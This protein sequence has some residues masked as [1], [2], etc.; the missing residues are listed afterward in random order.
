MSQARATIFSPELALLRSTDRKSATRG[1]NDTGDLLLKR[2]QRKLFVGLVNF[3]NNFYDPNTDPAPTLV[4]AGAAPGNNIALASRMFPSITF[5]LYDTAEFRVTES[6]RVIIHKQLFDQKSVDEWKEKNIMFVSDIRTQ[7][8][9]RGKIDVKEA[10]AL[11]NKD[12]LLQQDWVLAMK[13][14]VASLKFRPPWPLNESVPRI[15]KY[16]GNSYVYKQAWAPHNSSETRLIAKP[17]YQQWDW[18]IVKY[19]LQMAYHNVVIRNKHQY[20]NQLNTT[21]PNAPYDQKDPS[22]SSLLFDSSLEVFVLKQY[23]IKFGWPLDAVRINNL[24]TMI[25]GYLGETSALEMGLKTVNISSKVGTKAGQTVRLNK[26]F[27]DR[28]KKEFEGN[29]KTVTK[30]LDATAHVGAESLLLTRAYPDAEIS[31]MEIDIK[32]YETL[33]ENATTNP[34]MKNVIPING[35]SAKFLTETKPLPRF[36]IIVIDPPFDSLKEGELYLGEFSIT[37]LATRI[38]KEGQADILL[39][40]VPLAY[41]A[42]REGTDGRQGTVING[43]EVTGKNFFKVEEDFKIIILRSNKSRRR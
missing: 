14:R 24:R 40:H 9:D 33:R 34:E 39:V 6:D 43:R 37:D 35:D 13:P 12:M 19:D 2:G 17:P 3:L 4:Y 36:D 28:I 8:Y 38:L 26:L 1:V 22:L 7:E 21:D 10:D 30:I 16:L 11:A 41:T 23:F 25:T 5:H 42:I 31:A 32:I 29:G 27:V 18:D 15:F 20:L